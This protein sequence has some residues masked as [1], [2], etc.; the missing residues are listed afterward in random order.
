MQK[1]QVS[2]LLI[3]FF[4]FTC[5]GSSIAFICIL[6]A[7]VPGAYPLTSNLNDKK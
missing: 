2:N 6:P 5:P 3:D 1:I 7:L 4:V